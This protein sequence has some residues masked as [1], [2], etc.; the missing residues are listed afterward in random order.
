M[1][2]CTL[3]DEPSH[4]YNNVLSVLVGRDE[5]AFVVHEH[6]ISAKSKFFEAASRKEW[7]EGVQNLIRLPEVEPWIF[8]AYVN[9]VYTGDV[10]IEVEGEPRT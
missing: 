6:F 3:A 10:L 9:W 7:L 1:V 5:E 4:N 8:K 2:C